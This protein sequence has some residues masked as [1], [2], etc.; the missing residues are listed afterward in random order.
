[1]DGI[2]FRFCNAHSERTGVGDPIGIY[3]GVEEGNQNYYVKTL[4]EYRHIHHDSHLRLEHVLGRRGTLLV[5]TPLTKRIFHQPRHLLQ[6]FCSSA[7]DLQ[8]TR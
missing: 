7:F 5:T 2:A 8:L 4:K 1:M 6:L 3:C